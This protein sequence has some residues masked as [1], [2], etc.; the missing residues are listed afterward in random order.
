MKDKVRPRQGE[1]GLDWANQ[2]DLDRW[3]WIRGQVAK[4][5]KRYALSTPR[6]LFCCSRSIRV[7]NLRARSARGSCGGVEDVTDKMVREQ[8]DGPGVR[9]EDQM[10]RC[11]V[12][13]LGSR[14]P[15]GL[16]PN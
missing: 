8:G 13:G 9:A 11:D 1:G 2:Q 5:L 7:Y 16:E 10:G 14:L 6:T 4:K 15:F 3:V 12:I